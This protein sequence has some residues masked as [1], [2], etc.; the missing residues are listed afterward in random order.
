MV[1]VIS[2][3]NTL[4]GILNTKIIGKRETTVLA[5]VS[6]RWKRLA[7]AMVC[8]LVVAAATSVSAYLVKPM[9]DD[10]FINRDKTKLLLI[11]GAALLI[12]FSRALPLMARN[13]S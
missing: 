11:P 3:N 7:F 9:L 8:M 6:A 4:M 13:I 2:H 1:S 5:M 10:I 12:F